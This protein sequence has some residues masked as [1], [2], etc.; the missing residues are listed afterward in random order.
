MKCFFFDRVKIFVSGRT[1]LN[2][3]VLTSKVSESLL[4]ALFHSSMEKG[5]HP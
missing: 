1:R 2:L 3:G 5:S 4:S